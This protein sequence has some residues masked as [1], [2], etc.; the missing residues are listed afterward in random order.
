MYPIYNI[1]NYAFIQQQAAM[2]RHQQQVWQVADC[3]RKLKDFLD[4]VKQVAPEYQPALL[5]E[6]CS[7]IVNEM[8]MRQ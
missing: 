4:S 1:Y 8:N 2:Y 3:T 7:V 6:C 5:G